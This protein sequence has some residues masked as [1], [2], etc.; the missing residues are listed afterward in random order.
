VGPG[1]TSYEEHTPPPPPTRPNFRHS[2]STTVDLTEMATVKGWERVHDTKR[3]PG[4][5]GHREK[6]E[7][8]VCSGVVWQNG[9]RRVHESERLDVQRGEVRSGRQ[10]CGICLEPRTNGIPTGERTCPHT[11]R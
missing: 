5:G 4:V 6:E 10:Y 3:E 7:R 9:I 11:G 8:R 1:P 2:L